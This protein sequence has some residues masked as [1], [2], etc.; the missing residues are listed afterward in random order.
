MNIT[1]PVTV[2]LNETLINA[3]DNV[4]LSG[5]GADGDSEYE[6]TDVEVIG[7]CLIQVELVVG[8]ERQ[9]GKFV[10]KDDIAE[11]LTQELAENVPGMQ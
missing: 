9:S 3:L 1:I 5:L 7:D 10:G 4:D 11:V 8:I 2:D 6:V